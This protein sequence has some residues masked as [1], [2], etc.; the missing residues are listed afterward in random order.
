M[1]RFTST[2]NMIDKA[3]LAIGPLEPWEREV[4]EKSSYDFGRSCFS[5]ADMKQ[6]TIERTIKWLKL[7][8]EGG[9]GIG[10]MCYASILY[11]LNPNIQY[12]GDESAI[13]VREYQDDECLEEMGSFDPDGS[14]S[15]RFFTRT[16]LSGSLSKNQ[17][18]VLYQSFFR[19]GLR[20]VHLLPLISKYLVEEKRENVKVDPSPSNI[21]VFNLSDI[22]Q[23]AFSDTSSITHLTVLVTRD[24][25]YMC[26]LPFLFSLL[27]NLKELRLEGTESVERE[28]IDLS[29]LQQVDTSKLNRLD[30]FA[31]SFDSLSPLSLC[32]LSS[33][34]TLFI[35]LFRKGNGALNGLSSD[36]TRSLK[37]LELSICNI[38]DLSP[39][40]D[41]DIS[42]LETL[43]VSVNE[44]LS[45]LSPLRGSD[46]SSL[47]HINI[48]S[49]R[50]SDLSPLCEC[51][52]LALEELNLYETHIEDLSPLSLLD[53][54]RLKKPINLERSKVSD[55]SPLENIS[56]DGVEVDISGTP[57][58]KKMEEEGLRSPQTISKVEVMW[59]Q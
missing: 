21:T 59:Q 7:S 18:S 42:A 38:E 25:Q 2:S 35:F 51:K 53:L 50:I 6:T 8:A 24:N 27:P 55:L 9:Y 41:C 14:R 45:S 4:L 32:D 15:R 46:L 3:T 33:L 28:K 11:G 44:S 58:M 22:S 13:W 48:S 49:T 47:K 10:M 56:Y 5:I 37:N 52:G 39:L 29:F 1:E 40:S 57:A 19:S 31:C 36:I 54:S 12:M 30:I 20:E 23:I 43:D 26:F 34:H 16:L 17:D